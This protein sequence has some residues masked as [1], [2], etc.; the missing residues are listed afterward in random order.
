[1]LRCGFSS[2]STLSRAFK[3]KYGTAPSAARH[4]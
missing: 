3:R 1:A 4:S 2:A